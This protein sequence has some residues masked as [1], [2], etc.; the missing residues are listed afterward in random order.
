MTSA[1]QNLVVDIVPY[2]ANLDQA[3][4]G[5]AT[6]DRNSHSKAGVIDAG[7]DLVQDAQVVEMQVGVALAASANRN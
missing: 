2:S 1:C 5:K 3:D 4:V 6:F 7:D